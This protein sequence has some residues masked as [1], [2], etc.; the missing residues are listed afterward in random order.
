MAEL[1]S[2]VSVATEG[3]RVVAR[4]YG[5]SPLTWL[6]GTWSDAQGSTYKLS[7]DDGLMSVCTTRPSGEVITT[8]GLITVAADREVVWGKF[9]ARMQYI[10]EKRTENSLLWAMETQPWPG[11]AV[12]LESHPITAVTEKATIPISVYTC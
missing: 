3:R 8:R 6:C 5:P 10:L 2:Q 7:L 11:A 12:C 4:W 9:G 1:G